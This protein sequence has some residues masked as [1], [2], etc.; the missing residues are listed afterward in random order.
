MVRVR[1]RAQ[2]TMNQEDTQGQP[3]S[4]RKNPEQRHHP[5]QKAPVRTETD[6]HHSKARQII[7]AHLSVRILT[8]GNRLQRTQTLLNTGS[9]T[10]PKPTP[11]APKG[12]AV[13]AP[14]EPLHLGTSY[15]RNNSSRS[16]DNSIPNRL[17]PHQF[18]SRSFLTG[19]FTR[20]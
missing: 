12:I 7:G 2:N 20:K 6:L 14:C 11:N 17:S 9:G 19:I 15:K 3:W 4:T 8:G 1:R 5:H 16:H 18:G 13:S 10:N